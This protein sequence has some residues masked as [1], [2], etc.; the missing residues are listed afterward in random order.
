MHILKSLNSHGPHHF[1]IW[2]R[3]KGTYER[4]RLEILLPP[5]IFL[6]CVFA[7]I[8]YDST[9]IKEDQTDRPFM[10]GTVFKKLESGKVIDLSFG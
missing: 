10:G 8:Y 4:G 7:S 3:K 5:N 2:P 6:S 9:P 1:L